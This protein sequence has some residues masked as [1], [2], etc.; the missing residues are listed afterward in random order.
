MK[1]FICIFLGVFAM[2]NQISV[3]YPYPNYDD[4]LLAKEVVNGTYI[5]SINMMIHNSK[6]GEDRYINVPDSPDIIETMKDGRVPKATDVN[7]IDDN[8]II[9]DR[10]KSLEDAVLPVKKD[11]GRDIPMIASLA[12]CPQSLSYVGEFSAKIDYSTYRK[13]VSRYDDGINKF[14]VIFEKTDDGESSQ[15]TDG[16]IYTFYK[17]TGTEKTKI[18]DV[19]ADDYGVPLFIYSIGKRN[20]FYSNN[21]KI[22]EYNNNGFLELLEVG[23]NELVPFMIMDSENKIYIVGYHGTIHVQ[24]ID[25]GSIISSNFSVSRDST[26]N[27]SSAYGYNYFRNNRDTFYIKDGEIY[28]IDGISFY[29]SSAKIRFDYL[30]QTRKLV[31]FSHFNEKNNHFDYPFCSVPSKGVLYLEDAKEAYVTVGKDNKVYFTKDYVNYKNTDIEI[32]AQEF[33]YNTNYIIANFED[34]IYIIGANKVYSF[35]VNKWSYQ[36]PRSD[37]GEEF[38]K[39]NL[40]N[41]G[42]NVIGD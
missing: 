9:Y 1:F 19:K 2:A 21:N 35:T 17:I 40:I 7:S 28:K 18:F 24:D 6:T 41:R 3:P 14:L 36:I 11:L 32:D 8:P 15:N 29:G 16:D 10:N 26:D 23:I 5:A 38:A 27:E 13:T 34:Y 20:F 39:H 37:L 33:L 22:Y 31:H 12:M 25:S 4:D 42:I 30:Y